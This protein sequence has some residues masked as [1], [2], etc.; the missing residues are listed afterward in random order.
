MTLPP[1]HR[2]ELERVSVLDSS[3]SYREGGTG[4]PVVFLHGNPLASRV[5]RHVLPH[6]AAHARCLAPDLIGM[7][8]S[9]KPELSYRFS[10][11]ARY[12]E[13]WFE[14]LALEQVL[15][16]GYDWGGVLAMDW[17]ARHPDRVR[18]LVVFET[19]L[20]PMA[21]S[22]WS[23]KGAEL[24]RAL[25]TPGAGEK[26]VLDTNEFLGRSLSNGIRRPLADDERAAYYAQ[27]QDPAS[28]RPML[29]WTRE[30][31]IDGEPA[32]VDAVV[33]RYDAWLAG[34]EKV[35][36][37]LLSFDSPE[38]LQPSPTG[39]PVMVEWARTHIASLQIERL[40][41]AGHHAPED[42]PHE[43]SGAI[44]RFIDAHRL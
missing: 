29:Q 42:I 25:R 19:F 34:S 9:G 11:H 41:V 28:R 33:R 35:P 24:F 43:I 1:V 12:L 4:A 18:G 8:D 6:V 32:D 36:K 30:I 40:G 2:I 23:P 39:S 17:A 16:V 10:E 31:P 13:A 26:L 15:L 21:W 7:G 5:W 27:Y 37:L 38:G 14:A 3:M 22:E 44:L 20:R